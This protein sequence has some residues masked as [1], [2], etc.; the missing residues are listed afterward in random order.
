MAQV[1]KIL[2]AHMNSL[3]WIDHNIAKIGEQLDDI[4]KL[5]DINRRNHE[6]LHGA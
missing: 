6:N 2:N 5:H 3:Q 1:G 4:A